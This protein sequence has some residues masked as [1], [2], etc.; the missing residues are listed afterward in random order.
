MALRAVF[1]IPF[2]YR[3]NCHV[4]ANIKKNGGEMIKK[5]N[6]IIGALIFITLIMTAYGHTRVFA[7]ASGTVK[8]EDG[9]PIQG[10]KI[11]LIYSEDGTKF[12]LTTDEKGKWIKAN[13]RPGTWTIGFMAEGYEPQN[14][15]VV[16]S[17]IKK[18]PPIDVKLVPVPE[19]PLVKGDTLYQQKEYAAALE[20]YKKVLSE[21]PD[22]PELYDKIGIC[23]YRL[24]E[25]DKAVEYF[26]LMLEKEPH[27]QDTLINLSAIYFKKGEFDEGMKYFNQLDESTLTDPGLFYNIGILFFKNGQIDKAIEYLSKSIELDPDYVDAYYQLALA[28][29]NKGNR[30]EAKQSLEKVIQLAPDSEKAALAKN[31][32]DAMK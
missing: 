31:I 27:S 22:V 32:I 12:E 3:Y 1:D 2:S 14:F 10:A 30:N 8:S 7:I 19:S 16:L 24:D 25:L 5:I 21:H 18:N 9:K 17:S 15:N 28:N 13:I 23:Y 20:E 6:V 4:E 26:K 29:L 11:I